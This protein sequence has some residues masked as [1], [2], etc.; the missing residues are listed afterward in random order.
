MY[1]SAFI[2]ELVTNSSPIKKAGKR[3]FYKLSKKTREEA[4]LNNTNS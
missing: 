2:S 4:A 3:T 1:H